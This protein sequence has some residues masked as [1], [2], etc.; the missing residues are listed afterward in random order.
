MDKTETLI[1][2]KLDDY[3]KYYNIIRL[4]TLNTYKPILLKLTSSKKPPLW[5]NY[6]DMSFEIKKTIPIVTHCDPVLATTHSLR[7]HLCF[8]DVN[9]Q[10]TMILTDTQRNDISK[11]QKVFRQGVQID[12]TDCVYLVDLILCYSDILPIMECVS[13]VPRFSNYSDN[14]FG[15][16]S[17]EPLNIQNMCTNLTK[18][19]LKDHIMMTELT[20]GEKLVLTAEQADSIRDLNIALSNLVNIIFLDRVRLLDLHLIKNYISKLDIYNEVPLYTNY[21]DTSFGYIYNIPMDIRESIDV[22]TKYSLSR[23]LEL[24]KLKGTENLKLT[25]NQIKTIQDTIND[26]NIPTIIFN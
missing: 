15:F 26:I 16:M 22:K 8:N 5:V 20:Y 2:N 25:E 12:N 6:L 9:F 19:T 7:E 24:T 18:Y 23:H 4:W 3:L 21:S 11:L 17:Y 10:A 1:M 14:S 13:V